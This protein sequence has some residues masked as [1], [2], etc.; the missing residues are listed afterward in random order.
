MVKETKIT[1]KVKSIFNLSLY[2]IIN[3]YLVHRVKIKG[4]V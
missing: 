1:D 4:I 3:C 2:Q